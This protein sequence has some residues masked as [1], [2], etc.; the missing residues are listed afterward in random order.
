M[1]PN[2]ADSG[3][4]GDSPL[5]HSTQALGSTDTHKE[6]TSP[7]RIRYRSW[8][9]VYLNLMPIQCYN[10]MSYGDRAPRTHSNGHMC[11]IALSVGAS[12]TY[13]PEQF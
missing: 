13:S 5:I 11:S 10:E 1:E 7:C 9:Q 4:P 8:V 12:N 3:C 2:T 6:E